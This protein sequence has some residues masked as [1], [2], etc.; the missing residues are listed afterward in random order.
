MARRLK[1]PQSKPWNEG[2]KCWLPDQKVTII[3]DSFHA[4]RGK[5]RLYLSKNNL[6]LGDTDQ[7]LHKCV[8]AALEKERRGVNAHCTQENEPVHPETREKNKWELD[9]RG[10]K[11]LKRGTSGTDAFAWKQLHLAAKDGSLD[12]AMVKRFM[13]RISCGV[14]K[15]HTTTYVTKNPLSVEDP[16]GWTVHFH[17]WVNSLL[18]K[19]TV[20][21]EE[22]WQ[23]WS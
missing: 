7:L 11:N 23:I 18:K 21:R 20:T 9:G 8:C 13:G 1:N 6:D 3:A 16:F 5:L 22:A 17:N 15:S 12:A 2:F 4:V 14:C 19:P 10:P